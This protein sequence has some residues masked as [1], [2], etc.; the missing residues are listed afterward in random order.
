MRSSYCISIV[1]MQNNMYSTRVQCSVHT[2]YS[3]EH[4]KFIDWH[5]IATASSFSSILLRFYTFGNEYLF[6]AAS[7]P[8]FH[9]LTQPVN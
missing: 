4:T 6:A 5:W 8:D 7:F 9:I 1:S 3:L 2:L